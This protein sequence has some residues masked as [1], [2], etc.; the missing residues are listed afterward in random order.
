MPAK[1]KPV[2]SARKTVVKA[3]PKKTTKQA[4]KKAA[5]SKAI[6]GGTMSSDKR[7]PTRAKQGPKPISK[8][9]LELVIKTDPEQPVAAD[10]SSVFD[11]VASL[12]LGDVSQAMEQVRTIERINTAVTNNVPQVKKL[13]GQIRE[14][15]S[16][17]EKLKGDRTGAGKAMREQLLDELSTA[18][19]IQNQLKGDTLEDG[20]PGPGKQALEQAYLELDWL[21]RI[22]KSANMADWTYHARRAA[23]KGLLVPVTMLPSEYVKRQSDK[24]GKNGKPNPVEALELKLDVKDKERTAFYPPEDNANAW[25]IYWKLYFV[26][27]GLRRQF[28]EAKARAAKD[29][30]QT[31]TA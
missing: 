30:A 19:K 7:K 15:E 17:V 9:T 12:T 13:I 21:D 25:A 5:S 29:S 27:K 22:V 23:K 3:T 8:A 14:R 24:R 10:P 20:S 11:A 2:S 1:K 6:K 26:R 4:A 31:A 18:R 28:A 16:I